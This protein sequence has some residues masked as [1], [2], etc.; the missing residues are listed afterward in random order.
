VVAI[1]TVVGSAAIAA[2]AVRATKLKRRMGS[3][4]NG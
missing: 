3:K 2:R 4:N 1:V